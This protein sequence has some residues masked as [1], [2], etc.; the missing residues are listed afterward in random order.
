MTTKKFIKDA[1]FH[2]QDD[3]LAI[4]LHSL[5]FTIIKPFIA[6]YVIGMMAGEYVRDAWTLVQP[7]VTHLSEAFTYKTTQMG[8]VWILQEEDTIREEMN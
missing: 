6:V 3:V 2:L 7:Y 8:D 4:H 5:V 1:S